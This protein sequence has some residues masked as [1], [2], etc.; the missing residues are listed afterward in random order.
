MI[1]IVD[2]YLIATFAL[3]AYTAQEHYSY[4]DNY[5]K[6]MTTYLADYNCVFIFFN[7]VLAIA[8]ILYRIIVYIFFS[9]TLE[10]EVIVPFYL[11]RKLLI[12]SKVKY[13]IWFFSFI[14][15]S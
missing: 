12:N 9:A 5:F 8:I 15:S 11:I 7:L 1:S 6:A 4:A 3:F 10:G 13:L 14:L 2:I